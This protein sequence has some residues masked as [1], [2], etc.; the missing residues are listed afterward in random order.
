M[1]LVNGGSI[2]NR[3]YPFYFLGLWQMGNSTT[4]LSNICGIFDLSYCLGYYWGSNMTLLRPL[5]P[6]TQLITCL[7]YIA[8]I[9]IAKG[10]VQL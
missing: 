7:H 9:Y 2:I 8:K 6:W 3:A 5:V 1:E 4:Q 10:Y